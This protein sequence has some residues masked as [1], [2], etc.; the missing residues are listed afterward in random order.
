[1]SGSPSASS[2]P[3]TLPRPG[4]PISRSRS[5]SPF[6]CGGCHC[7]INRGLE[8]LVKLTHH[9]QSVNLASGNPIQVIFHARRKTNIN[10][11]LDVP[12]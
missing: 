9:G 11:H 1:L 4:C 12:L 7:P 3:L 6:T 10:S 8:R 2:T 5:R